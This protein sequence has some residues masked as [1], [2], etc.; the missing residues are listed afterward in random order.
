MP[1]ESS[2]LPGAGPTFPDR[3]FENWP[4]GPGEPRP[5]EPEAR[6][7]QPVMLKPLLLVREDLAG[8]LVGIRKFGSSPQADA[9]SE[10]VNPPPNKGRSPNSATQ[11]S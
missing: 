2:N 5:G 9:C 6:A 4:W 3:T 1:F 11:D 10:G 8:W 7:Q